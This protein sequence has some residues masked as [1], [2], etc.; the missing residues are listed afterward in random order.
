MVRGTKGCGEVSQADSFW[1]I[2]CLSG[3]CGDHPDELAARDPN[4]TPGTIRSEFQAIDFLPFLSALRLKDCPKRCHTVCALQTVWGQSWERSLFK[5]KAGC[6][7][8]KVCLSSSALSRDR[9]PANVTELRQD[10]VIVL[11]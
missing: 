6:L 2:Y 7:P 4:L 9:K 11:Q 5:V 1:G 10:P 8:A 3:L